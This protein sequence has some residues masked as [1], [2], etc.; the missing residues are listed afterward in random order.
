MR[1]RGASDVEQ[2][3]RAR[4]IPDRPPSTPDVGR[5]PTGASS[6]PRPSR[7]TAAAGPGEALQPSPPSL[8]HLPARVRETRRQPAVARHRLGGGRVLDAVRLSLLRPR[9]LSR[10]RAPPALD[11]PVADLGDLH[12]A[13]SG[14]AGYGRVPRPAHHRGHD[15]QRGWLL[16]AAAQARCESWGTAAW[17][18]LT[19]WQGDF[20]LGRRPVLQ[21]RDGGGSRSGHTESATAPNVTPVR[22]VLDG[23]AAIPP[24]EAGTEPLRGGLS[25]CD[26]RAGVIGRGAKAQ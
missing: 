3:F 6:W 7:Q 26:D 19:P 1:Q 20:I 13:P 4:Y 15:R 12:Q 2:P 22:E 23:G 16:P 10:T 11:Q 24:S 9:R 18:P 17:I 21:V 5:A 8:L 25:G 14:G